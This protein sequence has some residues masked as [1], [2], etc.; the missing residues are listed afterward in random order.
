MNEDLREK[1][2]NE[3]NIKNIIYERMS[4]KD[5]SGKMQKLFKN[6][7]K[8]YNDTNKRILFDCTKNKNYLCVLKQNEKDFQDKNSTFEN[9]IL[10]EK[11]SFEKFQDDE[12]SNNKIIDKTIFGENVNENVETYSDY[13]FKENKSNINFDELQIGTKKEE[14]QLSEFGNIL[15]K[16]YSSDCDSNGSINVSFESKKK[17]RNL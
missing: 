4:A 7:L 8:K 16:E 1:L 17:K 15:V 2:K 9:A 12:C 5:D 6:I 10:N 13:Q 14:D 3:L 11:K